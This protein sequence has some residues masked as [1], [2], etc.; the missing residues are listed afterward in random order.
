MQEQPKNPERSVNKPRFKNIK[1][2]NS[3]DLDSYNPKWYTVTPGSIANS[4][5]DKLAVNALNQKVA[6]GY[7]F[8]KNPE[9]YNCE[10]YF[11]PGHNNYP[12]YDK[13]H[14]IKQIRFEKADFIK[15]KISIDQID[16]KQYEEFIEICN[17]Y[18]ERVTKI[19][20]SRLAIR[21]NKANEL[22]FKEIMLLTNNLPNDL[23]E[24]TSKVIEVFKDYNSSKEAEEK[25]NVLDNQTRYK[26]DLTKQFDYLSS[27]KKTMTKELFA[28]E[29]S[30]ILEK[31]CKNMQYSTDDKV[32][33]YK[34][35]LSL[36]NC[37]NI[38][39]ETDLYN[40]N[41]AFN[42]NFIADINQSNQ[43]LEKTKAIIQ[44]L[45]WNN[46]NIFDTEDLINAISDN[47]NNTNEQNYKLTQAVFL[48]T[49]K[50]TLNN[51]LLKIA[52]ALLTLFKKDQK[53]KT[54]T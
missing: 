19:I 1:Y 53:Y 15:A 3:K 49:K 43:Y 24:S 32:N 44:L 12:R 28:T 18:N 41:Q 54:T 42:K 40:K 33:I 13:N 6:D 11:E 27:N 2:A 39:P 38:L 29:C 47:S 50:E 45:F 51:Q 36:S 8:L 16:Q 37:K 34:Q 20:A 21:A 35:I 14:N 25:I 4:N 23:S 9:L 46:A 17:Y 31:Y 30:K 26:N 48:D 52:E 7:S 10:L 5:T 22:G